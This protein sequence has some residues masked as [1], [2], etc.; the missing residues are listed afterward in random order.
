MGL[1]SCLPPNATTPMDWGPV[2]R[3]IPSLLL[4]LP[5]VL[6]RIVAL[7]ELRTAQRSLSVPRYTAPKIGVTTT[8][9]VMN[10]RTRRVFQPRSG[11]RG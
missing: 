11:D 8:I 10:G 7:Y 3:P 5:G 6:C 4:A 9:A 1:G 2:R